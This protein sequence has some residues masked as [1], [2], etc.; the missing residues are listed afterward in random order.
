MSTT[1]RSA[2]IGLTALAAAALS[3]CSGPYHLSAD[4]KSFGQ[5]PEGRAAGT[6]AFDR[7]PSQQGNKRQDELEAAARAALEKAGFKPAADA[8]S[9]D[10]LVSLGARISAYDPAPW[11]D[12]LWWRWRGSLMAWRYV[13]PYRA[14]W[15]DPFWDVRYERAVA[16]LLR[17][18]ASGEAL[19][20]AHAS[21]DGL[22]SGDGALIGALFEA[23]LAEFPK[24][25]PESHRVTIQVPR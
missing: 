4:A 20:E 21:N 13:G 19:Y 22:S 11:N 24:S 25:N 5:W 8:K 3:A 2:L 6:Y 18:R 10:I 1:R 9:A 14:G 15:R 17:D 12:P 23:A 7:L 16:V